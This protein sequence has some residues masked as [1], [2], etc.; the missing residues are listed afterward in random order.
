MRLKEKLGEQVQRRN[1]VSFHEEWEDGY[2]IKQVK[3]KLIEIAQVKE[4]LEKK[5]KQLKQN[6]LTKG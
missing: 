2:E 1:G 6:N 4:D 3:A 5:K